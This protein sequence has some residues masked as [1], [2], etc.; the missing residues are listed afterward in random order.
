LTHRILKAVK[1]KIWRV[2]CRLDAQRTADAAV[3]VQR[4]STHRILHCSKRPVFSGFQLI[5]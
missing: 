2:G 5:G 3:Q 1:S 4:L